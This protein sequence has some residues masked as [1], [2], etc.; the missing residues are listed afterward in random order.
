[1]NFIFVHANPDWYVMHKP[2]GCS[3]QDDRDGIGFLNALKQFMQEPELSLVHR[4]DKVTSG[5][6]LIGRNKKTTSILSQQFE[7]RTV[8]KFYLALAAGKPS[9]K[10]GTIIGDMAKARRG[11]WK[12][13]RSVKNPAKTQFFSVSHSAGLRW[14]LL[15]P[16]TGKTH[17]LRVALK[18]IGCPIL[19]DELYG[20]KAQARTYLHAYG[21]EFDWQGERQRFLLP[22]SEEGE[23]RQSV[24]VEY[25]NPWEMHW[26]KS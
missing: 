9:K 25:G 1:M 15:R 14:Y 20:A 11:A 24:P 19:G 5:L 6:L 10:Q 16:I 4:L 21:L 18:S 13:E 12:L 8:R 23:F 2:Q 7:H 26:P 3:V 22:P 17:Q